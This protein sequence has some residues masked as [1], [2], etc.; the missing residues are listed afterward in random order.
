M[1]RIVISVGAAL[2]VLAVGGLVFAT[3]NKAAAGPLTGTWE[4]VAHTPEGDEA[5]TM[6]LKQDGEAVKGSISTENGGQLDI[7]SGSYK[8]SVLDIRCETADA[9]Y[10]VTGK[11]QDAQLHGEWS[12]TG[13]DN[14][15]KGTWEAKRSEAKPAAQ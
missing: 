2:I 13:G 3:D 5:F 7:T 14:D 1:K 9:K 10:Q 15:N 6:T 4:G 12:K 11:L 8:N